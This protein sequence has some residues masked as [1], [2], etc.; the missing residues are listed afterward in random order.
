MFF[1][2]QI[3]SESVD[4]N[5]KPKIDSFNRNYRPA[6][7]RVQVK[8]LLVY[9]LQTIP[10]PFVCCNSLFGLIYTLL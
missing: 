8:I 1:L 9:L 7:D 2:F 10:T 6:R 5:A 3:F 4:F